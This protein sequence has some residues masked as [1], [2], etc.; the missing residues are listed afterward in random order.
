[1]Q[2]NATLVILVLVFVA[3]AAA[4]CVIQPLEAPEATIGPAEKPDFAMNPE[5]RILFQEPDSQPMAEVPVSELDF[6]MNPELRVLFEETAVQSVAETP[7]DNVGDMSA[8]FFA[9]SASYVAGEWLCEQDDGTALIRID[10]DGRIMRIL[11]TNDAVDVGTFWF[12]DRE[13]HVVSAEGDTSL[14]SVFNVTVE[15][16]GD[17]IFMRLEPCGGNCTD[18]AGIQWLQGL[19]RVAS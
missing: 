17:H 7:F 18:A 12:S 3:L 2:R 9:N 6:A 14:E 16:E 5:L 13:F 1:M 4:A 15:V 19:T 8:V 11:P 10:P